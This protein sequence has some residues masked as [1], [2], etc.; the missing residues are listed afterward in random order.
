MAGHWS[1]NVHNNSGQL[2]RWQ[3]ADQRTR[4]CSLI[5]C[6]VVCL[7][8]SRYSDDLLFSRNYLRHEVYL[9]C[10]VDYCTMYIHRCDL[11]RACPALFSINDLL[12]H[13]SRTLEGRRV[14]SL[15]HS[16]QCW[17]QT[18]FIARL[19]YSVHEIAC[20][21]LWA[22]FSLPLHCWAQRMFY[23]VVIVVN[24]SLHVKKLHCWIEQECVDS[25]MHQQLS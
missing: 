20:S 24:L 3:I 1:A 13:G 14:G 17:R 5:I 2:P 16:A 12:G 22:Y 23:V 8:L 7:P 15:L 25:I 4:Y 18:D 10:T 19:T 9:V 11:D 6:W 21:L